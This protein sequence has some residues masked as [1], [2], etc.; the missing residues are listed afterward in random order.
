MLKQYADTLIRNQNTCSIEYVV[1]L[2]HITSLQCL[3]KM[4]YI[5]QAPVAHTSNSWGIMFRSQPGQK[6]Q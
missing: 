4:N 6:F 2:E 3:L 1:I 5:S